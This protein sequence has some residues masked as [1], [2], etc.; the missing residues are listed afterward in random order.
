MSASPTLPLARYTFVLAREV[1]LGEKLSALLGNPNDPNSVAWLLQQALNVI[2]VV[3]PI[4]VII[5]SSFDFIRVIINNDDEAM[6]KAQK[7][8]VMRLVLVALLFFIPTLVEVLLRI[9]NLTSTATCG[10]Q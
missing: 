8:L 1:F 7:K 6:G 3:G 2:R 4:L 9:F 10:I 5:L